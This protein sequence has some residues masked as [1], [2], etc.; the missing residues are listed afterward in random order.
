[1]GVGVDVG[2]GVGVGVEMGVGLGVI[3]LGVVWDGSRGRRCWETSMVGGGWGC[4]IS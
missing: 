4:G 2:M 3:G 1:M